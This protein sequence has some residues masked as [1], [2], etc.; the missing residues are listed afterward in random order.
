MKEHA[1]KGI[2]TPQGRC[3]QT[4]TVSVVALQ[5][6]IGPR[7]VMI[8]RPVGAMNLIKNMPECYTGLVVVPM[9]TLQVEHLV[10]REL[11]GNI[12]AGLL[13]V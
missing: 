2:Q 5:E 4:T 6:I 7:M 3:L 11:H 1:E 8:L 10:V 12:R 13:L 9:G